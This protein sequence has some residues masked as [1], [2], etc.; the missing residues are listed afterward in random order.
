MSE[1][2]ENSFSL[3]RCRCRNS[4]GWPRMWGGGRRLEL[5]LHSSRRINDREWG[6]RCVC[7]G[8]GAGVQQQFLLFWN[9][10][11]TRQWTTFW[12]LTT[13]RLN[14]TGSGIFFILLHKRNELF[15]QHGY[16]ISTLCKYNVTVQTV[17]Y[18]YINTC[19]SKILY[20][21]FRAIAPALVFIQATK[22]KRDL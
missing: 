11:Y 2:K 13:A 22:N 17:G 12:K 5:L 16:T 18:K 4:I 14:I 8:G 1:I 19:Q 6:R 7:V 15:I 21:I 3:Y 10:K 9:L 20:K